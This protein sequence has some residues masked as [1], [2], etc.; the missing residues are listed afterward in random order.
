MPNSEISTYILKHKYAIKY[1]AGK[2][3]NIAR[4]MIEHTKDRWSNYTLIWS[5]QGDYEKNIKS[6][7]VRK[8][9]DCVQGGSTLS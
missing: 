6:F 8:F 3:N 5:V 9:I 1:Y 2:T 4:R 7:G